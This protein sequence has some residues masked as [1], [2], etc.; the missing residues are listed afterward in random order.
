[1]EKKKIRLLRNIRKKEIIQPANANISLENIFWFEVK[2]Y[3]M[4]FGLN[5]LPKNIH[6]TIAFNP[7][8]EYINLHISKNTNIKTDKPRI[9]IAAIKKTDL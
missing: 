1:M 2:E 9:T 7:S 4:S 3:L 6:Y 5:E 8:S